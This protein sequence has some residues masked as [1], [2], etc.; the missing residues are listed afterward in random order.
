MDDIPVRR[1]RGSVESRRPVDVSLRQLQ[2]FWAVAH[3]D[4]L[5]RAA[6]QLGLAQPSLSQ[7]LA[8]LESIVGSQLFD[9][10]SNEMTLTEAGKYLL[11]RSEQVLRS[12]QELE[13]GLRQF[14]GGRRVTVRIAGVNS[15]LRLLLPETLVVTSAQFPSVNFDVQEAA[16]NDIIEMLYGRR[17]HI[18][19]L[20]ANSVAEAGLGFL[21]VPLL[22]DPYVLVV[23]DWLRLDGIEDQATA[24]DDAG[25]DVLS[26][27]VEFNFGTQHAR[28]VE[29]WYTSML[30]ESRPV[31]QCRSFEVAIGMVR[32]GLGVCLAP[33]LSALTAPDCVS[34]LRLHQVNLP[35]RRLVALLPSQYRRQEPYASLLDNLA[36]R[37][38][39]VRLPSIL[40]APPFLGDATAGEA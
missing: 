21:Q 30:P 23:P 37:A 22:E 19:L 26:R 35:P 4:T 18:G 27:Y 34:G 10:R 6:K 5:T 3:S 40:P 16:P 7:Q 9:R 24:I 31:A 39:A 28:R 14:S 11:P 25:R 2:I 29:D 17:V 15:L 8:K 32:A 12:M 13:D 1:K 33:A 38:A 20:A 36:E